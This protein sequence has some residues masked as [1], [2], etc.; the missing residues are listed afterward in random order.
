MAGLPLLVW[1]APKL[2]LATPTDSC[3]GA[4]PWVALDTRAAGALGRAMLWDLRAGLQPS[5][6]DACESVPAGMPLPLARVVLRE[7]N[8]SGARFSLDVT[9][10]VTQKRVGRDLELARLPLDGRGLALAVAAEELLR[11]S[12]AELALRGVRS[13]ATAAPPEVRAV[14]AQRERPPQPGPRFTASGLRLA[15]ERFTG[16]Q[17]H[18]GAELFLVHP[19]GRLPAL[20]AAVGARR[21]LATQAPHGSIE[22]QAI[23]AELGLSLALYREGGVELGPFLGTRALRLAFEPS[24]DAGAQANERAGFVV[25]GRAGVSFAFGAPGVLRSYTALGAGLALKSFAASDSGDVV[26]SAAGLELLATTGLA[27]ELP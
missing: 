10:S 14:V 5:N 6:I 15:F 21:A 13:A 2:A 7:T 9:D 20:L 26:T 22:A 17:T 4:R 1:L 25:T 3:R 18:F 27:L 24:A 16:G 8:R 12:W 23:S 19:F 11:A